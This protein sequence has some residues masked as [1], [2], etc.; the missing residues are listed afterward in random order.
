MMSSESDLAEES[1]EEEPNIVN[2]VETWRYR[3]TH[4]RL[5]HLKQ[6]FIF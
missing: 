1:V 6:I 5:K 2:E 3:E 4:V